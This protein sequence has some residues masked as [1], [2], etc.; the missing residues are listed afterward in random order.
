M[1]EHIY[2]SDLFTT[3]GAITICTMWHLR[4]EINY[5]RE[6]DLTALFMDVHGNNQLVSC[7]SQQYMHTLVNQADAFSPRRFCSICPRVAIVTTNINK[8]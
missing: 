5:L 2:I 1:R 7:L 8:V 3:I 6:I 4:K